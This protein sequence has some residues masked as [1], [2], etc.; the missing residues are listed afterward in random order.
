MVG[1]KVEYTI[2]SYLRH[3][4]SSTILVIKNLSVTSCGSTKET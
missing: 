3:N 4:L 1:Q 2:Y